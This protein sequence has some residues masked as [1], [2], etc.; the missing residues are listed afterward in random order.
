M[1]K[2]IILPSKR[3]CVKMNWID[4][5]ELQTYFYAIKIQKTPF[6]KGA[7]VLKHIK[8]DR[9]QRSF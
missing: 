1:E 8:F 4:K 6:Q 7:F 5:I 9:Y 2:L 3:L